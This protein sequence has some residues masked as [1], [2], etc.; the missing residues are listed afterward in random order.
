MQEVFRTQDIVEVSLIKSLLDGAGIKYFVFGEQLNSMI[1]GLV[2]DDISACRFMVLD[3]QL[4]DALDIL[5]EAG[6]FDE[7]EYEDE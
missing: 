1:G 2:G 7:E 6:L 4:D 5:E 3:E